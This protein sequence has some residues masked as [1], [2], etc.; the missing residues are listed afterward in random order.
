MNV[1]QYYVAAGQVLYGRDKDPPFYVTG[2]S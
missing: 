2:C 1:R